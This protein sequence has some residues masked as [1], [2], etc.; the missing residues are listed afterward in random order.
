MERITASSLPNIA[1]MKLVTQY[2]IR[3]V[4]SE[5]KSLPELFDKRFY[6]VCVRS[7]ALLVRPKGDQVISRRPVSA[8]AFSQS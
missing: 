3:L 1:W 2:I 7:L 8:E 6:F 5:R 4:L